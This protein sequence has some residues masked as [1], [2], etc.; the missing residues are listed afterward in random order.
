MSDDQILSQINSPE[1]LKKLTLPQ[2]DKLA[3]E[4]REMIIETVSN[5]GG[6]LAPSLGTVDLT[7]ALY[8]VFNPAKD[9]IIWDA[10]LS[11]RSLPAMLLA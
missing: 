6:H 8:S 9:K 10:F 1:Q 3:A 5:N 2:L 7:L 11:A 4:I